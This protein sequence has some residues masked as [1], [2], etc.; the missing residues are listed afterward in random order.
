[1]ESHRTAG[2]FWYWDAALLLSFLNLA[3]MH[4]SGCKGSCFLTANDARV[5]VPRFSYRITEIVTQFRLRAEN[6]MHVSPLT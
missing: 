5:E 1:M 3:K 4:R 6:M 2:F